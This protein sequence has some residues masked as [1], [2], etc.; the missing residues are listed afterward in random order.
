MLETDSLKGPATKLKKYYE[1]MV[2]KSTHLRN[3][4][5]SDVEILGGRVPAR[6]QGL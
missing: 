3:K 1:P 4:I 5:V 2:K 6:K